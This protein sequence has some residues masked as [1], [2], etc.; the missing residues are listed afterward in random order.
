MIEIPDEDFEEEAEETTWHSYQTGNLTSWFTSHKEKYF[1]LN[2]LIIKY[3]SLP[4]YTVSFNAE[5]E[6]RE[7]VNSL[8]MSYI[9]TLDHAKDLLSVFCA[10]IGELS[11]FMDTDYFADLEMKH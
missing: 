5:N 6:E 11:Y 8:E 9:P 1:T 10:C 3:D 2:A 4:Y 7:L